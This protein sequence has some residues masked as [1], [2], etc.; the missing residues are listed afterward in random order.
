M[1]VSV[2]LFAT[3][4]QRAGW[5]RKDIELDAG[6]SVRDLMERLDQ[7]YPGMG[8]LRVPVYV[9]VNDEYAAGDTVLS[10][11]DRI[12][13]FPPVSGGS[14]GMDREARI[15][16]RLTDQPLSMDALVRLVSRPDSGAVAAFAGIVRG[17]TQAD[18]KVVETDF[19]VYEAYESM[20]RVQSLQLA[21]EVCRKWPAVR[22]LAME[23]R[24]GRCEL[25]EPTVVVAV[26]S[27]HRHDG[28]FEAC[29]YTIDRLKAIIPI[30]KQENRGERQAWV[31]GTP[32][33][34]LD[35]N[36]QSDP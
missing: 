16:F 29:K 30:W 19:L 26:S 7:G 13:L 25:G 1:K 24:I 8:L 10:D 20:A 2:E 21:E 17:I 5:A 18:Q 36:A 14:E 22:G 23:H 12:A 31:E 15:H 35:I 11:G 32:Q 28:C 4:R 34:D 6:L 3:L 33:A 27:P 9:A